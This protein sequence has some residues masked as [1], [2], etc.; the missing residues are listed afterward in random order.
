MTD[1]DPYQTPGPESG[2]APAD[3][4][5]GF[6]AGPN[7][8]PSP[9]PGTAPLPPTVPPA[10]AAVPAPEV[11][12]PTL[13]NGAT[14][15]GLWGIKPL[16][17]PAEL[18]LMWT[19]VVFSALGLILWIT[20]CVW[21]M[22]DPNP[23]GE[24]A[25]LREFFV[26]DATSY[27]AQFLLVVPIIP[28][29]VWVVRAI[30]YA[31]LRSQAVQMSPAQFPEG[32][33]MVVEAAHQ[34]GL[35]RVPDAY[36]VLG[37]G[38]VNAFA[39][40]HGFR[41]FVA[42]HSDLFEVGGRARDPEALRF[43]IGHEVGHL[44]AGHVSWFRLVATALASNIPLL[45]QAL[46]RAQEYT[47]DNHGY[48][49]APQGVAGMIGLLS[50]GKYLGAQV[51]LHAM[52]DRATREKGL[53]LHLAVWAA[54][55]PVNT[56]RAHALRDR[57]AP[58]RIMLRPKESTAWFAP[59]TPTGS[60]A[61]TGWPTPGQALATLDAFGP[62]TDEEQFGRYPGVEYTAPRDALRLAD[63]TPVPVTARS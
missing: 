58:G 9:A 2:P 15:H 36:V 42:V 5:A 18:A 1:H 20:L 45:S 19:S 33:R 17:H 44:A 4:Y 38:V 56:W 29:V 62:R 54:T 27:G 24:L 8:G 35:R 12:P 21:L 49:V 28:V 26:G 55:H 30:L 52:A 34:F 48:S 10:P 40:G 32:Y 47:A 63:P 39:S 37:N 50:G 7:A 13:T 43:V 31:Q 41:R 57:R 3:P 53:W 14:V 46:S 23:T 61:S 16:R 22:T 11:G 25:D 51:N 60:T 6:N 59:S